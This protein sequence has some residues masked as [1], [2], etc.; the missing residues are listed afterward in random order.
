[1]TA[2]AAKLV[3]FALVLAP[4]LPTARAESVAIS[5]ASASDGDLEDAILLLVTSFRESSFRK[6]VEDCRVVGDGGRAFTS[7]QLHAHHFGGHS[8]RELCTDPELA[9]RRA[10]GALGTGPPL[11]RVARFMGRPVIDPEVRLRVALCDRLLAL[12]G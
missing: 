2:L 11:K 9:A 10:L 1:M 12:E 6:E 4:A 5:I 3:A 8:R 7:Y